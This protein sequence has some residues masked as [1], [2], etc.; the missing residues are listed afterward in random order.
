[1]NKSQAITVLKESG[2]VFVGF[3]S[4]GRGNRFYVFKNPETDQRVNEAYTC[5]TLR[6]LRDQA[7]QLLNGARRLP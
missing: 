7:R 3:N 6:Q 4:V 2:F 1:M 5:L